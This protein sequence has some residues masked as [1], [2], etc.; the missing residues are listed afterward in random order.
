M[1]P[2]LKLLLL[3]ILLV[4]ALTACAPAASTQPGLEGT[5]WI[6]TTLY[7]EPI[8]AGIVTAEGSAENQV[9]GSAGCNQYVA[10]YTT[11]GSSLTFETAV[12]QTMM[13]CPDPLMEIETQYLQALAETSS[14]LIEEPNLTLLNAAGE[15]VATFTRQV[16][17]DL[18]GTNWEVTS[19]NNGEGAV[20]SVLPDAPITAS[21][22]A[23]GSMVGLTGCNLYSNEFITEGYRLDIQR[24][25]TTAF[26]CAGEPQALQEALFLSSF[27]L[28]GNFKVLGDQMEMRSSDGTL[29]MTL[30]RLADL[31]LTSTRWLLNSYYDGSSAL[32]A[33]IRGTEIDLNFSEDGT[34][35]GTGGCNNYGGS[36]ETSDNQLMFSQVFMTE[37]ACMDP[38]GVMEQ[39]STYLRL[40]GQ[41]ASLQ[42][43]G[44]FLLLQDANGQVLLLF[45]AQLPGS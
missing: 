14:Y 38:A 25:A 16:P 17:T 45:R 4:L 10:N 9:S 3:P 34:I 23:D 12:A 41:I 1:K 44:N 18:S 27:G 36:Y 5:G 43:Q 30:Q 39:E 8:E 11:D 22:R 33:P 37:M 15:A 6:L 2:S 21:F 26:E 42:L 32:I 20:V 40:L 28:V 24:V 13:M 31:P 7:G 29:A 19:Y 35:G